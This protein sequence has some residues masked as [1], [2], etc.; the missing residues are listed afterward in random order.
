MIVKKIFVFLIL[1]FIL[2]V[3]NFNLSLAKPEKVEI[4]FF[5]SAI[6]PHCEKAKEFLKELRIK[7]PKIEIR[8]YEILYNQ[9][10]QKTL[11]EFYQKYKVLKREYGLV[12]ISFT[13]ND[14]FIGFDEQI[15]EQIENCIK[16]CL[17]LEEQ[18]IPSQIKIPLIGVLDISQTQLFVLTIVLGALDGFNPCAMWVLLFL[19]SL[20]IN[21]RSLKKMIIIGGTFILVSGVVY[22]LI[23][24]AWL[25]LFFAI[26]Y[27]YLTRIIIG[28]AAVGMGLW[29]LKN[30]LTYHP[31]VCKVIGINSQGWKAKLESGLKNT[32]EKV[33][34]TP[35]TF[36]FI[37]GVILLALGI[38]LVE[39]FC[40]AGLPALYTRIL[41]LNL[42]SSIS[43]YLYLLLYTIVFLLDE[44]II[45]AAAVITFK[46]LGFTE[47]YN[48]WAT[49]IGGVLIFILGILL[50][51]KPEW[52]MFSGY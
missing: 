5:Y 46:K 32:A 10:N 12:P 2:V 24:A 4:H 31:G 29:Q 38:N 15:A 50:I 40:S 45:F 35:L 9:E 36:I 23:L 42:L 51:F 21:A 19:I 41:A 22:Y 18:K 34:S 17:F 20:L 43:Y 30:F 39:F 6:C 8:E 37:G 3:G 28:L 44:I 52:L 11:K 1:F 47:K 16:E 26:S 49:L 13:T 14:Y 7:Y 25:N 33:V 48:Y 27:V